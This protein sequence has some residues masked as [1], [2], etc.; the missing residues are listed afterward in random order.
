[1]RIIDM[2]SDTVSQPT[3]EMRRAIFEAEVGDDGYGE[4]PTVNLLQEKIAKMVK[5]EAALLATSGTQSNLLA[6]L[7]QTSPGDEVIVSSNAH[8]LW[9]E[10]G[11]ASTIAGTLLRALPADQN[12]SMYSNEIE[13]ALKQNKS[14]YR[15]M[16]LLCLENTNTSCCGAVMTPDY[17]SKVAEIAHRNGLR[18]HM[19]G[20]RI[21]NAVAALNV[22]VSELVRDVDS[23]SICLSKGL[24]APVGSLFCSNKET[25][26]K[27]T[28]WR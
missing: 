9:S 25:I 15:K 26:E 7:S 14:H 5:K 4:D 1:M 16:T 2:R 22:P 17:I 24:G 23:V 28:R 27:A 11:G 20:A 3:P 10:V 19:D 18:V 21:F 13:Q 8:M 6:V 12:G